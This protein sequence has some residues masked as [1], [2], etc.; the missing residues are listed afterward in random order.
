[1]ISVCT[2]RMLGKWASDVFMW[3]ETRQAYVFIGPHGMQSLESLRR[4]RKYNIEVKYWDL[5]CEV[6]VGLVHWWTF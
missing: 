3:W 6:R 1:M 2:Y 4:R 5:F